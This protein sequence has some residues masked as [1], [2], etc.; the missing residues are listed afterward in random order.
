VIKISSRYQNCFPLNRMFI[1]SE[2]A[3][4]GG[5]F[6]RAAYVMDGKRIKILIEY[7]VS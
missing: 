2:D 6:G 5:P 4:H 3:R 1:Q 7:N